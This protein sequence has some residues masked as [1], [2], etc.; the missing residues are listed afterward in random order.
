MKQNERIYKG[1]NEDIKNKAPPPNS[2]VH[3]PS[4]STLPALPSPYFSSLF[5]HHLLLLIFFLFF[6]LFFSFF[7]LFF[8]ASFFFFFFL[9]SFFFFF[10]QLFLL[11]HPFITPLHLATTPLSLRS[12][13][14]STSHLST[15]SLFCSIYLQ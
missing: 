13:P 15:P 14:P 10:F 5:L 6:F 2:L 11:N 9:S 12:T 8:L 4:S 3:A 7:L 1:G